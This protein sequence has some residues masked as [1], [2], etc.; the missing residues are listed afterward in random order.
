[1]EHEELKSIADRWERMTILILSLQELSIAE[2]QALLC[3]TYRAL[4]QFHKEPLI[5][6]AITRIL[7]NIEEYLYFAS[8]L[9]EKE[10]PEGYYCCR[11]VYLIV[12]SFKEGFFNAEYSHIFPQLQ[13]FDD[14]RNAHVINLK[15]NFLPLWDE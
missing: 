2:M 5:P 6:K 8:L 11:Q 13:I 15:G 9:E 4:T 12:R 14:F 10:V 1:M 3:D 7:L